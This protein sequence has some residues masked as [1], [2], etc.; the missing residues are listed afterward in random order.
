[1]A[2]RAVHGS[3]VEAL[4]D[5][6]VDALP[7]ADPF[8]PTKIVV[9]SHLV[10][11][12]LVRE[13][14]LRRGIAAG[15]DLVTFDAF[16]EATWAG[17]DAA[18]AAGIAPLDKRQLAA[19]IASVLAD[20]RVV[21]KLPAVAAYLAAAPAQGDRAGPRRVQLAEHVAM[22][23]WNYALTRPDWIPALVAGRPPAELADDAT[24][25]WQAALI[26]AALEHAGCGGERT[27][28]PVPALPW[29][30]RRAK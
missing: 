7:A 4:L 20:D 21:A 26:G 18:R 1:M 2:L 28:A 3:R 16:L 23:A 10:S 9:G 13:L 12:W 22:L 6:L 19:A 25:R 30:R 29:A 15:L 11:R 27:C 14:A 8:A 5:A 17:D 24:A